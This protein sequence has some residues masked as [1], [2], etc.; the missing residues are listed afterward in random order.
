MPSYETGAGRRLHVEAAGPPSGG[1]RPIVLL[2]G[3]ACHA[4]YFAPQLEGLGDRFRLVAPDLR[5]HRFS[6]QPGD[7]PDIATLAG[8]VAALLALLP[9]GPAPVL[10]G[11]SMG[12]LVAFDLI[13]RQGGE[14]AG[15]VV[16]DMTPRVVNDN[17]W[18]RGLL[19]G[20]GPAQAERAP[21]LMRRDWPHWVET[22]LPTVFAA[23]RAPDTALRDWVAREMHACDA[24]AMAA[25][26]RAITDA[27]D[28]ALLPSIKAPTLIVRGAESQLY[29][30][31]TAAWLKQAMPTAEIA[32]VARAGH[33][34]HLEQPEIFNRLLAEFVAGIG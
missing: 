2:H 18:Q 30:P 16:V 5:G 6:H 13:G 12:A 1:A 23:G 9:S 32:T 17:D 24:D 11:W 7:R 31:D 20:Y 34:P 4:G 29:G 27:D 10:V 3:W 14:V 33:A 21:E 26:W 15:L 8:D 28:R 19:G 22:F 25:L